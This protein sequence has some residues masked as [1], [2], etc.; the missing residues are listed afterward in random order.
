[1]HSAYF[2]A[3]RSPRHAHR[4]FTHSTPQHDCS[5]GLGVAVLQQPLTYPHVTSNTKTATHMHGRATPLCR[6][7]SNR[8]QQVDAMGPSWA[9]PAR[10]ACMPR[11]RHLRSCF[12]VAASMARLQDPETPGQRPQGTCG[13]THPPPPLRGCVTDALHCTVRCPRTPQPT[14]TSVGGAV[15]E[16]LASR[17]FLRLA[18]HHS[19]SL[20]GGLRPNPTA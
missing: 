1:M 14:T 6:I 4:R 11:H 3:M 5:S 9:H 2:V 12:P 10:P 20:G 17:A 8:G 18:C 7:R 19:C 15:G 13:P 16:A